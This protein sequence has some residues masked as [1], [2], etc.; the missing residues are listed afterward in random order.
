M[1]IP[2]LRVRHLRKAGF[3]IHGKPQLSPP[4]DIKVCPVKLVFE[5]KHTT[6]RTD[7]SG[8]IGHAQENTAN[9]VL[10]ALPATGVMV[11]DVIELLGER[12]EVFKVHDRF[13]VGGKHDHRELHCRAF[14]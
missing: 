13:T 5:D 8:S 2:T 7:S 10:L 4:A 1:I 12:V 6:V 11:G 3:D 14:K 9:V